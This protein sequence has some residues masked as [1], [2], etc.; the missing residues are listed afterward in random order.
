LAATIYDHPSCILP[1]V[2]SVFKQI[3][4]LFEILS[5]DLFLRDYIEDY[6]AL[7]GERL[8]KTVERIVGGR[9]ESAVR[10]S[11]TPGDKPDS[12]PAPLP[13]YLPEA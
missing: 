12:F 1:H 4:A 5:P 9:T 6:A 13:S 11:L 2:D 10:A 8:T 3:E 7:G